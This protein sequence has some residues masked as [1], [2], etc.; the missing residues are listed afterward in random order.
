MIFFFLQS[1][2]CS[3]TR[4]CVEVCGTFVTVLVASA[5]AFNL[6]KSS[7]LLFGNFFARRMICHMMMISI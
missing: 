5:N 7:I 1:D 2:T 6:D 3:V 4:R